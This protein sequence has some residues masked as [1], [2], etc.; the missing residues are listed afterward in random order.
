MPA[1][2]KKRKRE[3]EDNK[4]KN[5]SKAKTKMPWTVDK[6]ERDRLKA[7]YLAPSKEESELSEDAWEDGDIEWE[8]EKI[9]DESVDMAGNH[10]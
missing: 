6:K 1:T 7:K 8:I 9:V 3:E 5:D 4:S 2:T 10:R